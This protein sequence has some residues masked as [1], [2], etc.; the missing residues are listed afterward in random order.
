MLGF[1]DTKVFPVRAFPSMSII[2]NDQYLR[3]QEYI[4]SVALIE[5]YSQVLYI[6]I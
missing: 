2:V 3:I 4:L 5:K 1:L 6:D